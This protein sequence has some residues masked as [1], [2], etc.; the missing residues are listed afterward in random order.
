LLHILLKIRILSAPVIIFLLSIIIFG[1]ISVFRGQDNAVDMRNYH[2]YNPHSLLNNRLGFDYA[3][4]QVHTYL[5]PTADLIFYFFVVTFPPKLVGFLMGGIHGLNFWLLFLITYYI[6][7]RFYL[8]NGR[9]SVLKSLSEYGEKKEIDETI[10]EDNGHYLRRQNRIIIGCSLL[11]G[12]VGLYGPISIFEM[13]FTFN[14]NLI[15]LFILGAILVL[16]RKMVSNGNYNLKD[17]KKELIT[18][19]ILVGIGIGLKL[20]HVSY[21]IGIILALTALKGDLRSKLLSVSLISASI[22]TG[23]LIS[24]GYWMFL[25]WSKFESPIFPFYNEIFRSPYYTQNNIDILRLNPIQRGLIQN[26]L[27]PFY[28]LFDSDYK[29][30]S[31][32]HIRDARYAIVYCLLILSFFKALRIKFLLHSTPMARKNNYLLARVSLSLLLYYT[33]IF[34]LLQVKQILEWRLLAQDL[35]SYLS[36]VNI[37]AYLIYIILAILIFF[38]VNNID[39]RRESVREKD[40]NE[41]ARRVSLFV[42]LFF[43]GSFIIWQIIFSIHRYLSPLEVLSPLLIVMLYFYLVENTILRNWFIFVSFILIIISVKGTIPN[44]IEW[45]KSF[46]RVKVPDIE[47]LDSS[48]VFMA[49][50]DPIAYL[51]PFFPPGARFIRL[52]SLFKFNN[53]GVETKFHEE[54]NET[55]RGHVGPFYLLSREHQFPRH[56]K[57]VEKLGFIINQDESE[58]IRSEHEPEGLRLWIVRKAASF[59][60]QKPVSNS[61]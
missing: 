44:R 52:E 28:F 24:S 14:D 59:A 22:A 25:M 50:K 35:T 56:K 55:I 8:T 6:L 42:S 20:A 39:L 16:I 4:A 38:I 40:F 9:S 26:L 53:P 49:G 36:Y 31:V 27:Y 51:I 12:A 7:K 3:P 11:V 32:K 23:V 46:F 58:G 30:G 5:N 29:P 57:L 34:P 37:L 1:S 41:H 21:G 61:Y 33:S 45:D 48:I 54:M 10:G 15:S 43:I 17:I 18:A 13:G 2:F 47:Q 60:M 19:G